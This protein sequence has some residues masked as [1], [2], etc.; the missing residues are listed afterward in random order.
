[1]VDPVNS[2]VPGVG[3][4]GPAAPPGGA[5]RAGEVG[6]KNFRDV[7]LDSIREVNQLQKEADT[8]IEGLAAGTTDNVAEVF[9]AVEKAGLA[10]RTLMEVRNKL[11]DAYQ[12]LIRMRV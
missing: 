6:G 2:G 10:F 1:M 5:A 9:T 12:E 7:L 8:A 3:P 4:V 11:V